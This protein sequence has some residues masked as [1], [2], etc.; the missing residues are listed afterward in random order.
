MND[1]RPIDQQE[2]DAMA[3][4][5]YLIEQA[6]QVKKLQ[7]EEWFKTFCTVLSRVQADALSKVLQTR[8]DDRS[9]WVGVAKTANYLN[10]LL[11]T[12]LENGR[13]AHTRKEE[14]LH[15]IQI[16]V[17]DA[18]EISDELRYHGHGAV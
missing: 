9:E 17:T 13:L 6:E 1:I 12:I 11:A 14:L 2:V 10:A 18:H 15:N 4:F 8:G 16:A 5:D 7:N 3:G